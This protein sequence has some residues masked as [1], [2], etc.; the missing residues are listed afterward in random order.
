MARMAYFGTFGV[1]VLFTILSWQDL[2]SN[3]G[4]SASMEKNIPTPKM[5]SFAGPTLKILYW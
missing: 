2:S 5:S 1:V 3:L 4:V